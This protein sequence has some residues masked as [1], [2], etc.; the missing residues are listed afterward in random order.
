MLKK[1]AIF[2]VIILFFAT[3]S[4]AHASISSC[5]GIPGFLNYLVKCTQ[6]L[7]L[8]A[9]GY[10]YD[11]ST[12][13]MTKIPG[14]PN[15]FVTITN[16][17]KQSVITVLT[18]A[19]IGFGLKMATGG[20]QHISGE[21][22]VLILK[23]L[24]VLFLT[25]VDGIE[26]IFPLFITLSSSMSGIFGSFLTLNSTCGSIP[27]SEVWFRMDCTVT[28]MLGNA[29]SSPVTVL[30]ILPIAMALIGLAF[31]TGIGIAP[32]M[33]V[34]TS[35]GLLAAMLATAVFGYLICFLAVTFLI[36]ILPVIA[37]TFLFKAFGLNKMFD[38][39]LD[40]I[41][42]YSLQP[43]IILAYLSLMIVVL[44][45]SIFGV[46]P[47]ITPDSFYDLL[48]NIPANFTFKWILFIIPIPTMQP[49][50]I[51]NKLPLFFI[52]IVAISITIWLL[53]TYMEN[54]VNFANEI[55]GVG[56]ST[57]NLAGKVNVVKM[58]RQAQESGK[59]VAKAAAVGAV[60]GVK[61]G[62]KGMAAGAAKAAGVAAAKEGA[63]TAAREI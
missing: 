61:G 27:A 33:F 5:S 19:V 31:F 45:V 7:T 57:T 22:V 16:G 8:N 37:P 34:A 43:I 63:K 1:F 36:T 60:K 28:A 24:F 59:R 3:A 10:N 44:N 54:V 11:F 47:G 13:T 6:K 4:Q 25:S 14:A 50:W 41:V 51:A 23:I 40:L 56:A 38:K 39:W 30:V 15:P 12:A 58:M 21:T 52:N 20:V 17:L 62:P 55:A 35:V 46:G 42:S 29:V 48:R 32:I 2:T 53:Y 26:Y 18:L 9:V 49:A